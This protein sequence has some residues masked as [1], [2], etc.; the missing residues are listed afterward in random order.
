MRMPVFKWN[1]FLVPLVGFVAVFPVMTF[2][3]AA[4]KGQLALQDNQSRGNLPLGTYNGHLCDD[5]YFQGIF[6]SRMIPAFVLYTEPYYRDFGGS[7]QPLQL[8]LRDGCLLGWMLG[9]LEGL[10]EA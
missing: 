9:I 7:R 10:F 6:Q 1:A 8:F 3:N 4:C 5:C 2:L